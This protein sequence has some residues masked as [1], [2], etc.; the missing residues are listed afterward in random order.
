MPI[1][2]VAALNKV[3]P[4]ALK[5]PGFKGTLKHFFRRKYRYVEAVKKVSF[6]IEPG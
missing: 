4:I 3:Y 2:D 5:E 1:I 6:Q